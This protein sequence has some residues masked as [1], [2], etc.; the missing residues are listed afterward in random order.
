MNTALYNTDPNLFVN[1]RRSMQGKTK[2]QRSLRIVDGHIYHVG[3]GCAVSRCSDDTH[4]R[5]VLIQA[6]F[7]LEA[8]GHWVG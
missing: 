8:T 4:A 3:E 6:G 7:V 5:K 1:L 2:K